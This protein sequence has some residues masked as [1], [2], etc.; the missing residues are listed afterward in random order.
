MHKYLEHVQSL[1]HS[2]W[3]RRFFPADAVVYDDDNWD[4][5]PDDSIQPDFLEEEL[6]IYEQIKRLFV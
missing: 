1:N 4:N 2:S 3:V 5:P 6:T